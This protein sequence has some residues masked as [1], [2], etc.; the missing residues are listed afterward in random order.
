MIGTLR[1]LRRYGDCNDPE[2]ARRSLC[3][4]D[5]PCL[6]G[7]LHDDACIP[8][9]NLRRCKALVRALGRA[10]M[11]LLTDWRPEPPNELV[12]HS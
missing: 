8:F 7:W 1:A 4:C 12:P 10:Q 3:E 9:L 5:D 2:E 11:C 6:S